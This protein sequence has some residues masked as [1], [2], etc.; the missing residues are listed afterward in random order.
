MVVRRLI[1]ALAALL[2]A[3]VGA[4][5]LLG[6]VGAADRRAMAGM[7][8]VPVLVVVK[9][10]AKGTPAEQLTELVT[11][12]TLPV[13]AVASGTMSDLKPV[14]GRVTTTD[15]QPGE[16]VLASRFVDPASL[17][18]PNAV[19]IPRGMQQLSIALESQRVLG[20]ELTPKATVGVFVSLP[21]DNT[22]PPQTHLVLHKVLVTKVVNG[23]VAAAPTE[24][25]SQ[26]RAAAGLPEGTL[27]VTLATAA[28]DAEK[29]VFG[30]E[31]GKIWLSLEPADAT[32]TGTR[33]LTDKS[34][35]K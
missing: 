2:L 23:G 19:E 9:P 8:T 4:V 21:K 15:L 28:P 6:Y 35:Y 5:L 1:A 27:M 30:A 25:D 34:V 13:K 10:V 32:E 33:V 18:D 3:G 31:H 26:P 22:R 29:I 7:E 12:K 24:G 14:S 11:R 20:G 17:L 16:Q